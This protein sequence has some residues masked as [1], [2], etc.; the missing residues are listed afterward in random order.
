[1]PVMTGLEATRVIMQSHPVPI[2]VFSTELDAVT[3]FQALAAG[4]VDIMHKPDIGQINERAFFSGMKEKILAAAAAPM[5]TH[6][7]RFSREACAQDLPLGV[8][9]SVTP[10]GMGHVSDYRIV[11][12]GASTGGPQ[13]VSAILARLP[14]SYP[15]GIVLVQH[16]EA[17]FDRGYADWLGSQCG[18]SVRVAEEGPLP[19]AGEVVVAPVGKH[20]I[21]SDNRI[22][23]DDSPPVVNQKPCVDH[24]FSSA[25]RMLGSRTLAV[26][27]TGMGSDGAKGC[28]AVKTAGGRCIVQ[29]R[30]SSDIFGMPKAAIEI[31]GASEVVALGD[32]PGRLIEIAG[33]QP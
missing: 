26:L 17:G 33:G 18:L 16:L 32:I 19:R 27:L 3:S 22:A 29:D 9:P 7:A 13:A 14:A 6:A 4:A 31:G 30:E 20:T 1:M 15:L 2:I 25:S 10:L 5:K 11:V 23:F 21:L 12:M 8:G 28:L 24:L